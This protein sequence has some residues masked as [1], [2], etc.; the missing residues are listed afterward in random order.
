MIPEKNDI[1]SMLKFDDLDK[2]YIIKKMVYDFSSWKS[3]T[4]MQ[5]LAFPAP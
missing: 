4:K 2:L 3:S 1:Y 5:E